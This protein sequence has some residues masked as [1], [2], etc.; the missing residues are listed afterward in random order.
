VLDIDAIK[1]RLD[2]LDELVSYLKAQQQISYDEYVQNATVR[3][4]VTT[5]YSWFP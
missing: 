1:A 4:A 5:K 2:K 3:G